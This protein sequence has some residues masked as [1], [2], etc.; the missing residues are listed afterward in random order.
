MGRC[1]SWIFN[2]TSLIVTA[3]I[4]RGAVPGAAR[5]RGWLWERLSRRLAQRREASMICRS[6]SCHV[7][8]NCASLYTYTV[9]LVPSWCSVFVC[10]SRFLLVSSH[11]DSLHA[12]KLARTAYPTCCCSSPSILLPSILFRLSIWLL[13]YLP[14]REKALLPDKLENSASSHRVRIPRLFPRP[15]AI[16]SSLLQRLLM[17]PRWRKNRETKINWTTPSLTSS[18][19]AG[20]RR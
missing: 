17:K 19:R 18:H 7:I 4:R 14:Q 5:D 11:L 20:N 16:V 15:L 2:G 8:T 3:P 6:L 12:P 13:L 10:V 9:L 1:V